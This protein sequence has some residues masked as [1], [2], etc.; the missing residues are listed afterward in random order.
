[1][2]EASLPTCLIVDDNKIAR[3]T[4]RQ[5]LDKV[6][7]VTIVGECEDAVSAKSF[8]EKKQIDILFLDIEMPGMSGMELLKLLPQR[9]LTI[10]VTA[11]KGYAVEAFE[12]NVVDYLVKPFALSRILTSVDRAVELLRNREVK[13]DTQNKLQEYLFIKDNKVI[14][15]LNFADILWIE[16]KGDYVKFHVSGK[17]HIVHGSLKAIEENFPTDLF[18]RVHRSYVIAIDKID[19]IEDRVVY[20]DNQPI[21]ISESYKDILLKKLNLL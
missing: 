8:L 21:P 3:I 6:G 17:D 12:L 9:P 11:K 20:I 5:I 16:A 19:Y 10:L 18:I 7:T 14:R 2:K 1:M 4:L 13:L 15:K